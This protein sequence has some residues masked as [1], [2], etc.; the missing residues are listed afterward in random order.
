MHTTV[1][2]PGIVGLISG[3]HWWVVSCR[4]SSAGWL[5]LS[6]WFC[7]STRQFSTKWKFSLDQ[8]VSM[9][10]LSSRKGKHTERLKAFKLSKGLG[11][12][13]SH[14]HCYHILLARARQTMDLEGGRGHFAC[15]GRNCIVKKWNSSWQKQQLQYRDN[16][17]FSSC[18][19][20]KRVSQYRGFSGQGKDSV[21]FYDRG[22][23]TG[24]HTSTRAPGMN[25]SI[26]GGLGSTRG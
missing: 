9:D 17:K 21:G 18:Q 1:F 24:P 25:P 10:T 8:W 13:L 4:V 20:V 23:G 6:L 11:S 3:K 22:S 2:L 7:R 16:R 5:C 19:W 26:D 15:C 14:G 12:V